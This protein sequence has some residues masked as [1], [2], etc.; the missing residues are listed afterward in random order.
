MLSG[1]TMWGHNVSKVMNKCEFWLYNRSLSMNFILYVA[2]VGCSRFIDA[3]AITTKSWWL[4]QF[5]QYIPHP[6]SFC[7][8]CRGRFSPWGGAGG[9]VCS[10]SH[11]WT[12]FVSGCDHEGHS[13]LQSDAP[14]ATCV[15]FVWCA[16]RRGR[17]PWALFCSSCLGRDLPGS[18]G[19]CLRLRRQ[20]SAW[21]QFW[22]WMCPAIAAK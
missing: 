11:R 5:E 15:S 20:G 8:A 16:T 4:S 1:F 17:H 6:V 14:V 18:T 10:H 13:T 2:T 19:S 22:R 3:S 12:H 7:A 9:Y 21:A